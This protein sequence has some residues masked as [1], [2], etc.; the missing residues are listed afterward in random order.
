[1]A[2]AAAENSTQDGVAAVTSTSGGL[3]LRVGGGK[4]VVVIE[5][6]VALPIADGINR[7]AAR[8]DTL[9]SDLATYA[10]AAA[11]EAQV[12]TVADDLAM[13]RSTAANYSAVTDARLRAA[14]EATRVLAE[15]VASL[16]STAASGSNLASVVYSVL[17]GTVPGLAATSCAA[18]KERQVHLCRFRRY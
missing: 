6:G 10:P 16:N 17:Y 18:I 15:R 12:K 1:M 9:V 11:V 4:Q 7:N 14:E 3:E 13:V 8:I 5:G 2:T